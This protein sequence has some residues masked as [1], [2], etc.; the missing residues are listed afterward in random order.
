VKRRENGYRV[1]TAEDIRHL[2]IIRS[3]RCANY[4]LEAILRMLNALS[5]NANANIR[6]ILNTPDQGADILSVCDRLLASLKEAEMN[7]EGMLRQI[8]QMKEM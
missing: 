2:K 6:H 1:Y 5:Q 4:S 8:E 3:L 7:A